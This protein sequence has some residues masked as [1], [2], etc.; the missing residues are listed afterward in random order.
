[1][2]PSSGDPYQIRTVIPVR[3]LLVALVGMTLLAAACGDGDTNL[4]RTVPQTVRSTSTAEN[5]T[6]ASSN[7]TSSTLGTTTTTY[8][9]SMPTTSV[10]STVPPL[11]GEKEIDTT[12]V[13]DI[14]ERG[15]YEERGPYGP[16]YEPSI[17]AMITPTTDLPLS[18]TVITASESP[19]STTHPTTPESSSY[20][21]VLY[22]FQ[23]SNSNIVTY[24]VGVR[25][26]GK[27]IGYQYWEVKI[28]GDE[29]P[30]LVSSDLFGGRPFSTLSPD[31]KYVVFAD[32]HELW[33][34]DVNRT[35]P[36]LLTDSWFSD[37]TG[38]NGPDQSWSPDSNYFRYHVRD[39][40]ENSDD[41]RIDMQVAN[42]DGTV[43][44]VVENGRYGEWSPDGRN[45]F[46][47]IEVPDVN[48]RSGLR[49][50][51]WIAS[52]DGSSPL[53]LTDQ[54]Y[55]DEGLGGIT[56]ATWSPDSGK[57]LYKTV[58]DGNNSEN[59]LGNWIAS[60]D[61]TGPRRI[62]SPGCSDWSPDGH[63]ILCFIYRE[64]TYMDG[65]LLMIDINTFDSHLLANSPFAR[66][67]ANGEYI[68]YLRHVIDGDSARGR[69]EIWIADKDSTFSKL[70][71][72]GSNG[73]LGLDTNWRLAPS[74]YGPKFDWAPDSQHIV[75]EDHLGK[76]WT[77][78]IDEAM[79]RQL[80]WGGFYDAKW[81]P[82]GKYILYRNLDNSIN[83]ADSDGT[84]IRKVT[85][86]GFGGLYFGSWSTDSNRILYRVVTR[87][88]DYEMT[89]NELWIEDGD[90][91]NRRQLP[92]PA[93][94]G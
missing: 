36:R 15:P 20:S 70:L 40:N 63:R 9:A 10:V 48:K 80:G 4:I 23:L 71:D 5:I 29:P 54:L 3:A 73:T 26:K 61:G 62:A 85:D 28:D 57:L 49:E 75:Y 69:D 2:R 55:L 41:S 87:D 47:Y 81:S 74:D 39:R 21:Y 56:V 30:E 13:Q 33:L 66:W 88:D 11:T 45:I 27:Q 17:A 12:A 44:Q 8:V 59:L 79:P 6:I 25:E 58:E 84:N 1:M 32:G 92:L 50:E 31:G 90:G 38:F 42:I 35:E 16:S 77:A 18:D 86:D 64:S 24:E 37:Y 19:K 52:T 14:A 65:E 83:V 46:Y 43:I 94:V 82:D 34:A 22:N 7:A 78:N 68:A 91:S 93:V 89:R 67:S 53:L 51:L 76:L 72:D 60:T